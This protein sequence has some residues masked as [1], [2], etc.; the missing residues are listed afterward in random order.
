LIAFKKKKKITGVQ[1]SDCSLTSFGKEGFVLSERKSNSKVGEKV[2]VVCFQCNNEEECG[3]WMRLL[4]QFVIQQ[5]PK[6]SEASPFYA[7]RLA[8]VKQS[9]KLELEGFGVLRDAQT[10]VEILET[11]LNMRLTQSNDENVEN[12][13][14]VTSDRQEVVLLWEANAE[15]L[16]CEF[17]FRLSTD[18]VVTENVVRIVIEKKQ[19]QQQQQQPILIK[20]GSSFQ[21]S[22]N[23]ALPVPPRKSSVCAIATFWQLSKKELKGDVWSDLTE[24]ATP[25]VSSQVLL[26]QH[27]LQ[28][29]LLKFDEPSL[30]KALLS[31]LPATEQDSVVQ[32][33]VTVYSSKGEV[34]R[35]FF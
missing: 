12:G 7:C 34:F 6:K 20:Q 30:V 16:A 5:G 3:E 1:L 4:D 22:T 35:L 18:F 33:V 21:T 27:D 11:P 13:A 2:K 8:S 9:V 23:K 10:V 24:E 31:C 25:T 32:A 17:R 19:Q 26:A 28:T 14:K 29:F 15:D